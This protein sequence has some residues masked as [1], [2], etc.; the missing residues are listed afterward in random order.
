[1][2]EFRTK[3]SDWL[4]EN[5]ENMVA[6]VQAFAR[7][8]SV[9][10][11]DLAEEGAPFGPEC[12][13]M[14]DFALARAAEMG[15][16]VE[17][18]AGYCGSAILGDAEN[19]IGIVAHLDVVP[20]GDQWVYPPYAA[21]RVDDFLIGRGVADN[22]SAAVM[23]LYVM[24]LFRDLGIECKHGIRTIMGCAEETGMRD[25]RYY[26]EHHPMPKLSLI[27]DSAFP[28][29]Y[30]QKGSLSGKMKIELGEQVLSF[31]GGEVPNMV[32]P[33]ATALV[34]GVT[35]AEAASK[36]GEGFEV[37][38]EADGVRIT[39]QGIAAHAARPELGKSAIHMLACALSS[40]GLL[41]GQSQTA[42]ES[43]CAMTGDYHGANAGI[44][45]E[46]PDTGK[47]TMV[48]GVAKMTK[49]GRMSLSLDCR[50]SLAADGE[51]D[52]AAFSDYAQQ[53]GFE[54]CNLAA[55][56][57][58]YMP[59]DDPRITSL[60]ELYATLTGE[61]LAPYTMGGGT[62]A[63]ELENAITFGPA[64][65]NLAARPDL[66][67]NHGGAHAPDEFLHIPSFRRAFEIYACAV[68]ALDEVI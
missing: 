42:M 25:M 8:R 12:R 39:A 6:D 65:P 2:D 68:K 51:K 28:A 43:I 19:C 44:A 66:P 35:A 30:A 60:T 13:E 29:N 37:T 22:K 32:P 16:A 24:K 47:T 11:A 52:I 41:A 20:E 36:F 10:R 33:H 14:L 50:L 21:T 34:R 18:H 62:Y 9:S 48:C 26:R 40:S 53:L 56:P 5:F 4:N 45:N 23:G 54:P 61:R 59:K 7:I 67:E 63:R 17:D 55:T 58:V 1:M 27:P 15:F 64:F 57:P 3:I 46:D 49:D 38:G 31:T